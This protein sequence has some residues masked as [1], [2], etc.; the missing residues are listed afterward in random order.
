MLR[1]GEPAVAVGEGELRGLDGD[2]DVVGRIPG[3]GADVG[4]V[5]H[6]QDRE[7]DQPLAGRRDRGGQAPAVRHGRRL[8]EARAVGGEVR[9]AQRAPDRL[10]RAPDLGREV[11]LVERAAALAGEALERARESGLGERPPRGRR[12][13]AVE[14]GRAEGR[15][16]GLPRREQIGRP[17]RD[18]RLARRDGDAVGRVPDRGLEEI[19][20]GHRRA[21]AL[22]AVAVSGPEAVGGP[23]HRERGQGPPGRDLGE[24]VPAVEIGGRPRRRGAR[25]LERGEP[26]RARVPAEP[27]A[28]AAEPR[29]V[30]IHDGDRRAD[31]HGG[32]DRGAAAEE[33]LEPGDGGERMGGGDDPAAPQGGGP[34]GLRH[35]AGWAPRPSGARRCRRP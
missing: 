12:R 1:I 31:G 10:A 24:P 11:P 4:P 9:R 16:R 35:R 32:V 15:E 17:R 21:E 7:R 3:A 14:V 8:G 34:A 13:V 26:G 27:E 6:P 30:G 23:G 25:G 20:P 29:H 22:L 5:E 28:V 18:T 2:V 19:P 33:H